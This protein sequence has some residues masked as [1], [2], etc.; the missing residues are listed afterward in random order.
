MSPSN[1]VEI[2]SVVVPE[3]HV[4]APGSIVISFATVA[5]DIPA[6]GQSP[7]QRDKALRS[8]WPSEPL[9]ASAIY[10]TTSRY[11]GFGW[12][13]IGPP[14]SVHIVERVLH[15]SEHGKGWMNFI[16]K[17]L[18]DLFTQDNGAFIEVVR[19]DDS[20]TSPVIQLNHLDSAMCTRTGIWDTPVIYYDR[21]GRGHLLKWYQVLSLE[22][23]PSPVES[24]FGMQYC[25]V[26]RVL[27]MAQILRDISVYKREKISGR[28]T[29]AIHLVSGIPAREIEAAFAQQRSA[30][31]AIP[32]MRYIQPLIVS[33]LDPQANV[34]VSTIEMASL[35]DHFDEEQTMRWYINLFALAFGGDYQDYAP[36]PG[37]NLGS[38]Q[39]SET[40][41]LKS[42]GKGPK[43]FMSSLEHLFN[44]HGI[45][46][47]TVHYEYGDQDVAEDFEHARL[48]LV[49][50]QER[51]QRIK[52]GEI[53]PE[54]AQQ[55][56]VDVGDLDPR[57]IEI[58]QQQ[59]EEK[60][61]QQQAQAQALA[62]QQPDGN[63]TDGN[64][65]RAPGTP[66][67]IEAFNPIQDV[68]NEVSVSA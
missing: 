68:T 2:P 67:V 22:E 13:L 50:A 39:Q 9:L 31:D 59:A 19:T 35:P 36:L 4:S 61:R 32:L 1:G 14:R 54:V 17:V 28:F 20:P 43:L 47:D 48:R 6:W 5:D 21:L 46:P 30:N 8:F 60:A 25:V 66:P 16:V 11:A 26:T 51:A 18:I 15:N 40:L 37:G 27:R 3:T 44:N 23:F 52:S 12:R 10:S 33:S 58:L 65:A 57:Y 64:P 29:R 53:T 34:A 38:S 7:A 63:L 42:R 49:R 56:A 62:Q 55:I 24:A 41:H 45:M